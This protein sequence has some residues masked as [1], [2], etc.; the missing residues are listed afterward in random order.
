MRSLEQILRGAIAL[1]AS[2]IL[3]PQEFQLHTGF[4]ENTDI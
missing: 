4:T 1:K 3:F 2:D